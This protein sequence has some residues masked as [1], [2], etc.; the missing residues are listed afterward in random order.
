MNVPPQRPVQNR[1]LYVVPRPT[2]KRRGCLRNLP[3]VLF[4]LFIVPIFWCGLC[5]VAYLVI[6]P[7]PLD[8]MVLG[9][10]AR[11]GEGLL[12]RTDSIV[13]VGLQPARL[14]VSMLSIPRDLF[15]DVPG[16]GLQRIN[17]INVLG[18]MEAEGRGPGLL[19]EAI[20]Q[21]FGVSMDRYMRMDFQGFVELIDAVGGVTIDVERTVVDDFYPTIDGGTTS[22]RFEPGVQHMDG[23]RALQYARTRHGDDDYQR[24]ERQQQVISALSSK[25]L[26][27]VNWPSVANVVSRS[28]DT[29]VSLWDMALYAPTV[30]LNAGRFEREVIDRDFI[31]AASDGSAIPDYGALAPWVNERFE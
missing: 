11:P 21:S 1:P 26:N 10:D 20:Q 23:E 8:V 17:A 16:Y 6:P 30:V 24:A 31:T 25:L 29:N 28:V 4:F 9:V 7:P 12:T 22:I 15:I 18:E 27:P 3:L 13:L 2:Q 14:R 19:T 5:L